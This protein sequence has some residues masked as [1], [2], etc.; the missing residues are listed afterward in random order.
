MDNGSGDE[1][2]AGHRASLKRE[3]NQSWKRNKAAS[4]MVPG[5]PN[6]TILNSVADPD[7]EPDP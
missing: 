7:P 4:K 6:K 3:S 1:V 2:E 5:L